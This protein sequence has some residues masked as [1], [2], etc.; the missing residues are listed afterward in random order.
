MEASL[1]LIVEFNF[2][3]PFQPDYGEKAKALHEAV[4]A[5]DW[6]E[7]VV[8]GSGGIGGEE[9]GAIWIFKVADYGALGRLVRGDEPVAQAYGAF[10]RAMVDVRDKVREEVLFI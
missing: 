8:A 9:A 2:P 1:Y 5:C 7:E 3:R 4:E 6:V 10:F